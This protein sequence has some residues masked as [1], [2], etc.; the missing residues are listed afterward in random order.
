MCEVRY[1]ETKDSLIIFA[2]IVPGSS[3]TSIEGLLDGMLKV[4]IAAQPEKGKANKE[5]RSFLAKKLGVKKRDISVISGH[6]NPLKQL[7]IKMAD[8]TILEKLDI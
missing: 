8:K 5:L 2:K 3:K 4:K 6:T 7:E 1:K